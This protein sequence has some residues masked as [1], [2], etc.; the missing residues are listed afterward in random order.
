MLTDILNSR[1]YSQCAPVFECIAG[2]KLYGTDHSDS[3]ID[4]K[5]V[6]IYGNKQLL[7]FSQI[8]ND[9]IVIN[10]PNDAAYFELKKFFLL[11]LESNPSMIEI[12]FAP[13]GRYVYDSPLWRNI[14]KNRDKFLSKLAMKT[15]LGYANQQLK[16]IEGHRNWLLCPPSKKPNRVDF[17][18]PENYSLINGDQMQAFEEIK[19]FDENF[20]EIVSVNFLR[21]L[22]LEKAY[23]NAL[24]NWNN[25][26][27]WKH[28][29]NEDRAKLEEKVGYDTKHAAHLVRLLT[30]GQELLLTGFITFPRPDRMFLRDILACR[31]SYNDLMSIVGNIEVRFA[32]YA[33]NSKLPN[34]PDSG[35]IEDL[36]IYLRKIVLE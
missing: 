14:L 18:L 8:K 29:R 19:K 1:K 28:N 11:C 26:E 35:S 21:V 32:T 22:E 9:A 33:E 3:D 34:S 5:G 4:Y 20:E 12:L 2:S 25:Y 13:S 23:A 17:G 30:E 10:N 15:F 6:F 16:R 27:Q 24:R 31:Y 36:C 7:G